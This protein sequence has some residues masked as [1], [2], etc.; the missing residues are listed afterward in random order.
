VEPDTD[1]SPEDQPG[2]TGR[3]SRL[4]RDI[5]EA[6]KLLPLMRDP[7]L[8]VVRIDKHR[9]RTVWAV[10]FF[11]TLGL[12]FTTTGVQQFLAGPITPNSPLWWAAWTVEP[13][14]A[15]L[16]LT[17]LNFEATM[18][19]HDIDPASKH[20][21]QLKRLLLFSTWFMNVYPQFAPLWTDPRA[22]NGGSAFVHTV[23]PWIVYKIAE[24]LPVIQARTR[25]VM[26]AGY[27]NADHNQDQGDATAQ[28]TAD[29]ASLETQQAL[30]NNGTSAPDNG[31]SPSLPVPSVKLPPQV[32][33]ALQR[34][35]AD[36]ID[37]G[38][39]FTVT[40]VKEVI[41]LDDTTA[42]QVVADLTVVNGHPV[43]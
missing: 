7:K 3:V 4:V 29:P 21:V 10:Y 25:A 24:V 17:L 16:L 27:A 18:L 32:T 39:E 36:A 22:F 9:R 43:A 6:S 34:A 2:R 23:I 41:A 31:L 20:L 5:A 37:E 15:G 33:K 11:L 1:Q 26:L 28:A 12:V 35:R 14:F 42:R 8:T 19:A 38:R 40:D 30:P 13:M